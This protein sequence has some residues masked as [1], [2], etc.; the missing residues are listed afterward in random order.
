MYRPR[1]L[2]LDTIAEVP[3]SVI[4]KKIAPHR[5]ISVTMALWA[6]CTL[7]MGFCKNATGLQVARIF[8]GLFE[9]G[10]SVE[11]CKH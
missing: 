4:L 2:T 9:G 8:L 5:F 6:L 7:G 11:Y 10:L 3:S 1:I